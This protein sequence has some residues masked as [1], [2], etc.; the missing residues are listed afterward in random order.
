[1]NPLFLYPF[2]ISQGSP[3]RVK[4]C[5]EG[6][7]ARPHCPEKKQTILSNA[8]KMVVLS[9]SRSNGETQANIHVPP[10]GVHGMVLMDEKKTPS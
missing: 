9:V 3:Y 4:R 7:L 10:Y 6:Q 8:S 1:M 5:S 2:K